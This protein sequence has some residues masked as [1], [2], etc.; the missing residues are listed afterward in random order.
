MIT[1][2]TN[3]PKVWFWIVSAFALLWNAMGVN[4]YL[5]QAYNTKAHQA[6]YNA[7][8]LEIIAQQPAWYA[9]AFAIAV[10]CGALGC[11]SLLFRKKWAYGL[12]LLSAFGAIIQHIYIFTTVEMNMV[13]MIMPI[14]IIV[15][16]LLLIFFAKNAI[17][18]GWLN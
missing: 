17:A 7:E 6:M 11:I 12:F 5:Q 1:T 3:K 2:S 14:L 16:C 15:V 8:Q 9:A 18:K 13:A 4:A 10:C